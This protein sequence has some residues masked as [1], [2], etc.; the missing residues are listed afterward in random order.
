MVMGNNIRPED[1]DEQTD[2]GS[3]ILEL[4]DEWMDS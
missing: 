2:S 1:I 3:T 4:G